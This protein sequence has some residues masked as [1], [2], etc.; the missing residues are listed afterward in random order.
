MFKLGKTKVPHRKHTASIPAV[1]IDAPSVVSI[2]MA[3]H[4]GAP[5]VPC[6]K[7]GDKVYVG[8]KIAE[9]GGYVSAVIHSSVSGTVKKIEPYLASNG[10][11]CPAVVIESDGEMTPDP[12][13]CPPTVNSL[14]ELCDAV[15]A[16]GLVGLGGAGFPTAVKL[17]GAKKGNIKSVSPISQPT[18]AL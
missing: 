3:Q 6:V 5:A 2:P 15:R 9:A 7:V 17:D 12:A 10:R 11:S 14:D 1:R 13:I 16:S 8:T 4:I 18:H